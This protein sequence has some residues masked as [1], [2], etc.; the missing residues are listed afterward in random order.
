K[1]NIG[2][3][4]LNTDNKF[5]KNDLQIISLI[6]LKSKK[7]ND[8][9]ICQ[10]L[11]I[12]INEYEQLIEKA[13]DLELINL[14]NNLTEKALKIYSEILK[15]AKVKSKINPL[16]QIFIEEDFLYLP[17]WFQGSS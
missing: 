14:E 11:G 13:K 6:N 10:V 8:L 4:I 1:L 9:N 17:K 12:N 16:Q 5:N 15:S 3:D 7:K 2:N